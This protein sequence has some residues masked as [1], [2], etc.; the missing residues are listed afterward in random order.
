[1]LKVIGLIGGIVLG[2]LIV[3]EFLFVFGFKVVDVDKVVREVV[4]KG[5]KGLV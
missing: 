2:K 3:L 1:M 5:S 4:K